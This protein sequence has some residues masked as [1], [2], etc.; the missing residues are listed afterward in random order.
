MTNND[1]EELKAK[2]EEATALL[3][4]QGGICGFLEFIRAASVP[5]NDYD[6]YG[7]A[8]ICLRDM[9]ENTRYG[10][11]DIDT[12]LA[13]ELIPVIEKFMDKLEKEFENK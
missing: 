12:E 11:D 1:Y 4:R 7:G 5:E 3:N 13:K 9:H 6:A 8:G 2:Y 10:I